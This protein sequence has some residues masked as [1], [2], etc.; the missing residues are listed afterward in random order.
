MHLNTNDIEYFEIFPWNQNFETGIAIVDEQHKRLVEILNGLAAHLANCA[1]LSTLN[2]IFAEL[3]DYADYHFKT[4]EQVWAEYLEGDTWYISHQ[5]THTSFMDEVVRLKQEEGK[6]PFDEVIQN[7][8]SFLSHWL[9]YHILDTDKRMAK[10]LQAMQAGKD[11]EAA[12]NQANAEM[13]GAMRL[14]IDTVLKMYDSLS[15]RSMA[16]MREKTLRKQA[17][18]KLLNSEARWRFILESNRENVWDWD[19]SNDQLDFSETHIFNVVG[20][21][22]DNEP[23]KPH[24]HPQDMP[25]VRAEIQKHFRG[26]SDFFSTKYRVLGA[27]GGWSWRLSRGKVVSWGNEGQPLRMVGTQTDITERELAALIYRHSSQAMFITDIDNRIASINAAF[28]QITGYEQADVIGKSPQVLVSEQHNDHFCQYLWA[29]VQK[30]GSWQGEMSYQRKNGDIYPAVLNV[31][32][33]NNAKGNIDHYIVL[34]SDISEKK[35]ADDLILKQA[36]YDPLTKLPNRRMFQERLQHEIKRTRRSQLP[37]ALLYIDLDDFKDVNDSLGHAIGDQLLI[38]AAKRISQVVRQTDDISHIGGDEFTI[39]VSDLQD[40]VG[41]DRV[42]NDVIAILSKPF[43][44][45]GNHIYISASIGITLYPD[46]ADNATE[47]LKNA[48]QAMYLA[49]QNGRSGFQFFTPSMQASMQHRQQMLSD[50][51]L[52]IEQQQFEL[53]YQPIVNTDSGKIEKAEALIRWN[54]P[55]KGMIY[56]DEFIAL[57]EESGL[58]LEMGLW[59]FEEVC[60]HLQ[61][62]RLQGY[63]IQISINISPLQFKSKDNIQALLLNLQR[64]NIPTTACV[65]EITENLLMSAEGSVTEQLALLQNQGITVALDDF[66]TG[67]SS[68]SYIKKFQI[69]YLKIDKSFVCDLPDDEQDKVLCEAI[70]V[71]AKKMNIRVIA[72]GV[73]T[74]A[75]QQLLTTMGCDYVQG[76]YHA[77]PLNVAAFDTLLLN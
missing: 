12:R 13:N 34:F 38:E 65:V 67:Y 48:D 24:I 52:A 63:E 72:E 74:Q 75:Q 70:I 14:L 68:L 18:A 31:N 77:K 8:V 21:Q 23:S 61:Q 57:A 32:T 26:E 9:A 55:D 10:M 39:I 46:D 49:K 6:K 36:Y 43:L 30:T 58:I 17:E 27:H 15:T 60:R 66:G 37:F 11:R 62:W 44:L 76:Y 56:P 59:L 54:H 1:N 29:A 7:I 3:A 73:E 64:H 25:T 42:S 51:R 40:A 22:E 20:L 33:I 4:E 71:M 45:A 5:E 2:D 47:L 50:L 69:D 41:I 53:Y 19:I 16:L 28:S 35:Q